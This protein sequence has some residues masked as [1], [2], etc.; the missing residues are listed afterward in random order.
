M[1]LS[2]AF[3]LNFPA[4]VSCMMKGPYLGMLMDSLPDSDDMQ[5]VKDR[6]IGHL[7]SFRR[8]TA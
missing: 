1:Y 8:E 6:V 7:Q 2:W 4:T 3:D 5:K